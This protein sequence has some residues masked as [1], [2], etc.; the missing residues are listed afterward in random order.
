MLKIWFT[1]LSVS[2]SNFNSKP[3]WQKE[4]KRKL[5]RQQPTWRKMAYGGFQFK[6]V[7][8]SLNILFPTQI[9]FP[10]SRWNNIFV[11]KRAGCTQSSV[12]VHWE[13]AVTERSFP[14]S[15]QQHRAIWNPMSTPQNHRE[16]RY[17]KEEAHTPLIFCA[18]RSFEN[19]MAAFTNRSTWQCLKIFG[20][21]FF[22]DRT[23]KIK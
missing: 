1:M 16:G 9:F 4:T 7:C 11:P 23:L 2:P 13:L 15:L 12:N 20:L 19:G 8:N 6:Q 21:K 5:Q 14:R 22:A 18:V 3:F 10:Q 17:K